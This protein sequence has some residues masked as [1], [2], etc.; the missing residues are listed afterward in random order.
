MT[1]LDYLQVFGP[2]EEFSFRIQLLHSENSEVIAGILQHLPFES[3]C[4]HVVVAG[5]TIYTPFPTIASK[6]RNMVPRRRGTV[7]YNAT[8]QSICFCYGVVTESTPVNAF[9]QVF[10][11]DMGALERLGKLV[12]THTIQAEAIDK[13]I[14]RCGIVVP[15]SSMLSPTQT[16][17]V[18]PSD[19]VSHVN[20]TSS[21][22]YDATNT[23]L[24]D[25]ILRLRKPIEPI[26]IKKLRLGC[27][28]ART[29][30]EPA[31]FQS[32]IFLQGFLSTLGPH[33]FSRLLILSHEPAM[34]L[35][36]MVKQTRVFLLDTFNH[37]EF[38]ADLGLD[39]VHRVG[40]LYATAL[41]ELQTLEQWRYMTDNMRTMIQLWYRWVHLIF[42]WYMKDGFEGR[43]EEEVGKMPSLEVL[44]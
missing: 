43:S 2:G 36:L 12:Y 7:Y 6:T 10:D 1:A 26:E 39:C 3:F 44:R 31:I 37:F 16:L 9:A 13:K 24:S 28:K 42:P 27:V 23:F 18:E 5:E 34:H 38:L 33:V 32:L 4:L 29:G 14:I 41:D 11:A 15:R 40:E 8:S 35:G 20:R 19:P 21:G 22:A 17:S 30:T 25:Q